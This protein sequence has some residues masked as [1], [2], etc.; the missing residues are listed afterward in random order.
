VS[1]KEAEGA[2][3]GFLPSGGQNYLIAHWGATPSIKRVP[4][5]MALAIEFRSAQRT[6]QGQ[7]F[8]C[9]GVWLG[10]NKRSNAQDDTRRSLGCDRHSL[11]FD[12]SSSLFFALSG[13]SLSNFRVRRRKH[14]GNSA[15]PCGAIEPLCSKYDRVYAT[16]ENRYVTHASCPVQSIQRNSIRYGAG[17]PHTKCVSIFRLC[18]RQRGGGG[19]ERGGSV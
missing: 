9:R 16:I 19:L 14:H 1:F 6:S 2:T 13:I 3:L 12:Q 7:R 11:V 17:S 15:C 10:S 4:C 18:G 8:A 5:P